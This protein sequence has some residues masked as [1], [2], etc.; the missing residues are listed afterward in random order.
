MMRLIGGSMTVVGDGPGL[1]A[2]ELA[3]DAAN[4]KS[5]IELCGRLSPPQTS[6]ILQ[7]ALV[8]LCP[9][10][11]GSDDAAERYTSPMKILEMMRCGVAVVAT[12]LPTTRAMITHGVDGLLVPPNNPA[13]LADA[14]EQLLL[15]PKL[16]A[17][18]VQG[19]FETIH[20][21]SWSRRAAKLLAFAKSLADN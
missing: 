14:V 10:P 11:A 2:V 15:D 12:D 16:R 21:F 18:L 3:R 9:L 5:R 13:A 8:G 4:L 17:S 19:G 1:Q 7:R 6:L 20:S